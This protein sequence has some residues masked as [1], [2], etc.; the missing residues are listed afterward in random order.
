MQQ[1]K[2]YAAAWNGKT[3]ALV[4]TG[5]GARAQHQSQIHHRVFDPEIEGS[6]LQVNFNMQQPK[7]Y[8]ITWNGKA[9][10]RKLRPNIEMERKFMRARQQSRVDMLRN[11]FQIITKKKML[12]KVCK[13]Y[14]LRKHLLTR[15]LHSRTKRL[16]K[17]YERK[18]VCKNHVKCL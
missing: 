4:A 16:L 12:M 3:F 15:N 6:D 1:P 5:I 14:D 9:F 18:L 11:I 7:L 10:C 13:K 8:I 2:S 17:H